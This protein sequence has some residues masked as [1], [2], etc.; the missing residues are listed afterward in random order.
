MA[1]TVFFREENDIFP[2]TTYIGEQLQE[3]RELLQ[4]MADALSINGHIEHPLATRTDNGDWWVM[5]KDENGDVYT[6]SLF[7]SRF[8]QQ[9]T[10][11]EIK[12]ENP[13]KER[14]L[15]IIDPGG[16]RDSVGGYHEGY[17][18]IAHYASLLEEEQAKLFLKTV[19]Q[20]EHNIPSDHY[21]FND[22]GSISIHV[23]KQEKTYTVSIKCRAEWK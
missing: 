4:T 9:V 12:I 22:D 17:W 14:E 5:L 3:H 10:N 20:I 11:V 13:S 1:F 21:T 8:E 7:I 23:D 19:D 2:S 16:P 6:Y 18:T 15:I